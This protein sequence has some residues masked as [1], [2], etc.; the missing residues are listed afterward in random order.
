MNTTLQ[1]SLLRRIARSAALAALAIAPLASPATAQIAGLP[2]SSTIAPRRYFPPIEAGGNFEHIAQILP[3]GSTCS[4]NV[5]TGGWE[6]RPSL[7]AVAPSSTAPRMRSQALDHGVRINGTSLRKNSSTSA[8]LDAT[9]GLL[10]VAAQLATTNQQSTN[11]MS[12]EL[13]TALEN[14]FEADIADLNSNQVTWSPAAASIFKQSDPTVRRA[15][16]VAA[17]FGDYVVVGREFAGRLGVQ[18][19]L[20]QFSSLSQQQLLASLGVT[21]GSVGINAS[22]SQFLAT[23]A[24]GSNLEL[25]LDTLC[26]TQINLQLPPSTSTPQA[27]GLDNPT[28]LAQFV[29]D[30]VNSAGNCSSQVGVLA[31][32]YSCLTSGPSSPGLLDGTLVQETNV[33]LIAALEALANAYKWNYPTSLV[34]L[35][36]SQPTPVGA[37]TTAANYWSWLSEAR[38]A[39]TSTLLPARAAFD[40]FLAS[41]Q[42]SSVALQSALANV[43][44]SREA[45]EDVLGEMRSLIEALPQ[46][47]LTMSDDHAPQNASNPDVTVPVTFTATIDNVM[48]EAGTVA[49]ANAWLNAAPTSFSL[50]GPHSLPKVGLCIIDNRNHAHSGWAGNYYNYPTS[51][52][53]LGAQV[54]TVFKHQSGPSKG[55]YSVSFTAVSRMFSTTRTA[56]MRFRD[57]FRREKV[58]PYRL[59]SNQVMAP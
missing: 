48:L 9:Y 43:R 15:M 44:Q 18:A 41:P 28:V 32:P 34:Q 59:D 11:A 25:S 54:N 52:H 20:N 30:L 27:P 1:P 17:G 37:P 57:A 5:I 21:Y 8:S 36:Q 3:L 50:D 35:L 13:T 24:S 4:W 26:S 53:W 46:M 14:E 2:S 40:A 51:S 45:L 23:V 33:E 39:L 16:W 42:S 38:L 19:T 47:T 10:Q 12:L 6:L 49:A 22:L 55:L 31:L 56:D 29:Q 7:F 58:F